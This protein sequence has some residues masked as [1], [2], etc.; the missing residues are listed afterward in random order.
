MKQINFITGRIV[1][2]AFRVHTQL[3]PG[4]LES[5]YETVL[6]GELI[7][8]GFV[9]ERQKPISIVVGRHTFEDAFRADLVIESA[10]VVEIKSI[11]ELSEI[12]EKQLLTYI[13]LLDYR[14]GLL[15]NFNVAHLQEGGL[16]RLVNK[17]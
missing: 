3:G 4:L 9:V 8:E 15:F 14:A 7:D 5:V 12:H 10:V 2:A 1:S 13:R 17:L 6:A 11:K 16:R